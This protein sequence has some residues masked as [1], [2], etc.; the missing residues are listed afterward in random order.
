MI[1]K[2]FL[3]RGV[4]AINKFLLYETQWAD[5]TT[6]EMERI[7]TCHALGGFW[8]VIPPGLILYGVVI[9]G[10]GGIGYH[11][12]VRPFNWACDLWESAAN[13]I[14]NPKPKKVKLP[15]ATARTADRKQPLT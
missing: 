7:K 6:R 14:G 3:E 5:P 13:R 8:V 15:K 2:S 9:I 10:L 11:C 1:R 12:L 4:D